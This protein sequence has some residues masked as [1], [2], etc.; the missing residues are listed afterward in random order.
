MP[1]LSGTRAAPAGRGLVV[2]ADPFSSHSPHTHRRTPETVPFRTAVMSTVFFVH[3]DARV[4]PKV[5]TDNL[6]ARWACAR[7][8]GRGYQRILR[9]G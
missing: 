2:A 4:P 3:P 5:V 1:D 6:S 7:C 8:P 9:S